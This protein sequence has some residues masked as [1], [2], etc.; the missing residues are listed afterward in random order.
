MYLSS[1]SKITT[2]AS[3]QA[4]EIQLTGPVPT[5]LYQRFVNFSM[6]VKPMFQPKGLQGH[7]LHAA[8]HR[9]HEKVYHYDIH[10]QY[11][12]I[13]GPGNDLAQRF[14][15]MAQWGEGSRLFTYV[16]SLDGLF[17]F[18]ETGAEFGIDLLSKHTMHSDV[19]VSRSTGIV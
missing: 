6:F 10:T 4:N 14:L 11:G 1:T 5:E 18:T 16:M 17:R 19:A 3:F 12:R 2:D 9:Q 13:K 7:L 15:D 8:L